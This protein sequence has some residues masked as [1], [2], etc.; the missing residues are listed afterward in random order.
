MYIIYFKINSFK[1]KLNKLITLLMLGAIII[2]FL[3]LNLFLQRGIN[4]LCL[5]TYGEGNFLK[6]FKDIFEI[7]EKLRVI[8]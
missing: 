5:E 6:L 8:F 3:N 7:F 4:N 1:K 2:F